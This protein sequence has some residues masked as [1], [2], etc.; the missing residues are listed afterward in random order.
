MNKFLL[1]NFLRRAVLAAPSVKVYLLPHAIKALGGYEEVRNEYWADVYDSV[2]GYLTGTRPITSFRNKMYNAMN[3]AFQT[4]AEL[5]YV[6]GGGEVPLDSVTQAWLDGEIL[7]EKN[8][9]DNLFAGLQQTWESKDAIAEAFARADGYAGKLDA[10]Y[11][12]AMMNGANNPMLTWKLGQTETHC[13]TCASLDGKKH[14]AQW[15][16]DRD[17]IP[18]KPYA[19]MDCKGFN[20]DCMLVDKDGLEYSI[21]AS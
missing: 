13:D 6:N 11:A 20:C 18:R 1:Y 5:G 19:G 8:N 16:I 14:P 21:N 2:E 12:Q 15:Y 9:I 17:Y 4:G 10:I 7:A 3:S